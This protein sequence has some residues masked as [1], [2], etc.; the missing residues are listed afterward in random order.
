VI[1][2][3]IPAATN[4]EEMKAGGKERKLVTD[5]VGDWWGRRGEAKGRGESRPSGP[6]H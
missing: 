1:D 6:I 4:S 5:R 3:S 2:L